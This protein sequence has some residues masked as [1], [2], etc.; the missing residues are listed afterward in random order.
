MR[1]WF[2]DCKKAL[3]DVTGEFTVMVDMRKMK[4]LL[5]DS[6][7][8]LEED[9]KHFISK[10]GVG[11]AVIARDVITRQQQRNIAVRSGVSNSEVYIDGSQPDWGK[12]PWTGL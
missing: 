6:K 9:Q 11:S 5:P 12:R 2:E 4:T 10:G 7:T 8:I 3:E 1:Q